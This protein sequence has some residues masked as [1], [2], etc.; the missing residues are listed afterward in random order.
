M[1]HLTLKVDVLHYLPW[2]WT[3]HNILTSIQMVSCITLVKWP[4]C[5]PRPATEIVYPKREIWKAFRS[6]TDWPAKWGPLLFQM[7]TSS[8]Q[9]M[10][11]SRCSENSLNLN[12][13]SMS[14]KKAP[15]PLF[16][17][18]V[19]FFLNSSI[20]QRLHKYWTIFLNFLFHYISSIPDHL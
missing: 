10:F 6:S 20:L 9:L 7:A 14:P 11:C 1:G 15:F 8:S 19:S 3:I 12:L 18:P 2:W 16:Q 17:Y 13:T 4:F 5:L